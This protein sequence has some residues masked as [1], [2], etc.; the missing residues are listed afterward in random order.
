MPRR[1]KTTAVKVVEPVA[2]D[3][4]PITDA[5]FV[6]TDPVKAPWE[7]RKKSKWE[8]DARRKESG[9]YDPRSEIPPSLPL[10]PLSD[11]DAGYH[12]GYFDGLLIG[13]NMS[14][15]SNVHQNRVEGDRL[16]RMVEH[17]ALAQ[18]AFFADEMPASQNQISYCWE[19]LMDNHLD[20]EDGMLR[21]INRRQAKRI[22]DKLHS[23][24][25]A[26]SE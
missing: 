6:N 9:E 23:R 12:A 14:I 22:I 15:E 7:Y 11:Y 1:K 19:L 4:T 20:F 3:D 5:D 26:S 18:P 17:Y 10:E 16:V 25:S 21:R 13:K 24:N 8:Q 2:Q